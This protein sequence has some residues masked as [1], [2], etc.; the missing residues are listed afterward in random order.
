MT[1][2]DFLVVM[3]SFLEGN[4][5]PGLEKHLGGFAPWVMGGVMAGVS[6]GVAQ[7]I[8]ENSDILKMMGVM[9]KDGNI[10]VEGIEEFLSGAFAKS[11]ELRID[12]KQILGLKF[13]N[14]LAN[15]L[16]DGEIVFRKEEA[17][18]LITMLKNR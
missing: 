17:Q 2:N 10:S 14:P 15:S 7:K 16:L 9:D 6:R 11:P 18:E 1:V 3:A 13:D 4:L 8:N 5:G 12:P